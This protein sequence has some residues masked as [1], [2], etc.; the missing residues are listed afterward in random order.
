MDLKGFQSW[1]DYPL[2]RTCEK[3]T[4]KPVLGTVKGIIPSWLQ[5]ELIRVGPGIH[6]IGSDEYRH[7]FDGLAILHKFSILNG[8]TYY[9]SR[10][11]RSDAYKK[12]MEANRIVV[13]D[14]GTHAHADPCQTLFGRLKCDFKS[15]GSML[16]IVKSDNEITDNCSVN[17]VYYGDQLYAMTETNF[18]RRVD[19]ETLQTLGSKTNLEDYLTVNTATAHP[20]VLNDGTV[21]NLGNS[22]RRSDGPHYNFIKVPPASNSEQGNF[23]NATIIGEI[24]SRWKI[25]SA[26]FHSFGITNSG[27]LIFIEYPLCLNLLALAIVSTGLMHQPYSDWMTWYSDEKVLA[28]LYCTT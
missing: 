11:L 26:Y 28:F 7:I 20:H 24:P 13:S 8:K 6:K 10:A 16:N 22:F 2:L 1:K 4:I 3:E 18:L 9:I 17:L 21:I 14:F 19:P 5:G 25:H 23:A 27:K 15:I 12:N